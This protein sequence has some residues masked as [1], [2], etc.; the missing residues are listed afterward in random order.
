MGSPLPSQNGFWNKKKTYWKCSY[1]LS[2]F[3]LSCLHSNP[4]DFPRQFTITS[5]SFF[6]PYKMKPSDPI[7][8]GSKPEKGKTETTWPYAG[9][10]D[11]DTVLASCSVSSPLSAKGKG[12]KS[13]LLVCV[14]PISHAASAVPACNFQLINS[15][16]QTDLSEPLTLSISE[17]CYSRP[18]SLIFLLPPPPPGQAT[19]SGF[20]WLMHNHTDLGL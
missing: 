19:T 4:K 12:K 11:D 18:F 8:S 13:T 15:R 17:G 9:G 7:C 1:H 5:Q 6:K 10:N 14:Q 20:V 3:R 16:H 2:I